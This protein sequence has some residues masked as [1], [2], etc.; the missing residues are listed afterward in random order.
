MFKTK[1]SRHNKI[2]GNCPRKNPVATGLVWPQT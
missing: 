2:W 1:F